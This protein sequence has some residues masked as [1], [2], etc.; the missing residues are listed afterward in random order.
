MKKIILMFVA[1]F[2]ASIVFAQGDLHLFDVDNKKGV[3]TPTTIEKAFTDNGFSIAVNS[4]MNLPFKKQ[5]QK[6][7]FKVFTLLTVYHTK[8]SQ[9][10]VKKHPD[11]GVFTP[12]GVGIY[13]GLNE[14]TLHVSTLTSEAQAKILGFDDELLRTIEKEVLKSIKSAL[15]NAKH[16][17]SED[18]LKE[19]RSL[20]SKF[21]FELDGA[22][23]EGV[24][25]ELE[26]GLEN[27][28]KPFGFVTPNYM[29]FNAEMTKEGTVESPFDFYVTYSICK[30]KVIY[31]VSQ[32]RPEASAFAPCTLMV[33]KKKD[34][35]KV[36]LGFPAVYNWMSS[37]KVEDKEAKA[38]LQQAQKDFESIL[39][40]VTE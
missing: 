38:V 25:E 36:V 22:E 5:F 4:E 26:L 11:A 28:F 35:D 21:E 14:D 23:W 37:A 39:K 17:Y 19:S 29:D 8:L 33:Y 34:E 31:T 32:T 10:L 2:S 27:G 1:L 20:V 30:L 24:K 9:D 6:T 13:Q 40:E 7:D 15:A 18:S 16:G 12:L 3:I